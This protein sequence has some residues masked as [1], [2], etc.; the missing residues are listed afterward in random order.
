MSNS[1]NLKRSREKQGFIDDKNFT[2]TEKKDINYPQE[3]LDIIDID[4]DIIIVDRI[5]W[6]QR[7]DL[8]HQ[9]FPFYS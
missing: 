8:P 1:Q 9:K 4:T 3:L 7:P 5:P 6:E 2:P